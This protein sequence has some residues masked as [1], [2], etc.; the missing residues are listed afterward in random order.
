MGTPVATDGLA[1][2]LLMSMRRAILTGLGLLMA[3][4]A[5]GAQSLRGSPASVNR[6]YSQAVTSDLE[7]LR[8]RKS[9]LEAVND[10][11]LV[12]INLTNDL[13]LERVKY[14]YALPATRDFVNSFAR[15]YHASCGERLVV[16]SAARPRGEQPRNASPKSVHPTGMAVD[17]RKPT[18]ACLKYMRTELLAMEKAGTLE[19]T[20]ERHPV[21]FHVA[22]LQGKGVRQQGAHP[23]QS[24]TPSSP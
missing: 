6:M 3:G 2:S 17:F 9:L 8:S 15:K 21:H 18:G 24:P 13:D 20:E 22:V 14:P 1:P 10:G 16:T 5:A 7:F 11:E 19:A 4:G 23:A 12:P